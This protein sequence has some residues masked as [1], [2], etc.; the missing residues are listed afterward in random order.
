MKNI[1]F[2]PE[3]FELQKARLREQIAEKQAQ[4]IKD[5][6]ALMRPDPVTTRAELFAA[7]FSRAIAIADG[8][9]TGYKLMKRFSWLVPKRKKKR[10]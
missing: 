8:A 5:S 4:L 6:D 9:L 10:R 3:A 2:T 7:N 1:D